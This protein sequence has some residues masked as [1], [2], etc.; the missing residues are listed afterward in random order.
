LHIGDDFD[1]HHVDQLVEAAGTLFLWASMA[2]R[3]IND[4]DD[5]DATSNQSGRFA[6][7]TNADGR[8]LDGLFM[9]ILDKQFGKSRN[10]TR[11]PC[12]Q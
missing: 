3:F 11:I 9:R 4:L 6:I 1:V 12:S 10:L 5:G 7:I 8:L 2:C